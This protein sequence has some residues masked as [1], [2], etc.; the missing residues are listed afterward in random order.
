MNAHVAVSIFC[1]ERQRKLHNCRKGFAMTV[2]IVQPKAT[3][4]DMDARLA[5][6]AAS[7]N[8]AAPVQDRDLT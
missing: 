8:K 7:A 4:P 3:F 1:G 6:G 5:N 2:V